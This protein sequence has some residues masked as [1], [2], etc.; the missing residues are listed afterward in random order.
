VDL[1]SV[2]AE[3]VAGLGWAAG[4]LLLLLGEVVDVQGHSLVF[5]GGWRG[6][7]LH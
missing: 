2:A 4:L 3:D 5:V 6:R 7:R 1:S